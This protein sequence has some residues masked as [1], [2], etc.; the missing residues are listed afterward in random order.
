[1][2]YILTIWLYGVTIGVI[3]VTFPTL[4]SCERAGEAF[5][6]EAKTNP[7]VKSPGFACIPIDY[8]EDQDKP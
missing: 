3:P 2:Y 8:T 4:T 7:Q 1:M 6:K 5:L